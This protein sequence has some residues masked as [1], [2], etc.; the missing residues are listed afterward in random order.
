MGCVGPERKLLYM[1][2]T[3]FPPACTA[4]AG[5]TVIS[6]PTLSV[7]KLKMLGNFSL[8]GAQNNTE[9]LAIETTAGNTQQ[10]YRGYFH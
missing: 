4:I 3:Y 10:F 2:V 1:S 8:T 5:Y 6:G 9:Q 7:T